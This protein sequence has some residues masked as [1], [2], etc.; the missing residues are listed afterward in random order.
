MNIEDPLIYQRAMKEMELQEAWAR[1]L[2]AG[3]IHY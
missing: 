1:N 2:N 3:Q